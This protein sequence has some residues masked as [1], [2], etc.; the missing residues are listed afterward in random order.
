MKP[1][2]QMSPQCVY[3]P[4]LAG[5]LLLWASL[6]LCQMV[7]SRV[8]Y[9]KW[10]PGYSKCSIN[11]TSRTFVIKCPPPQKGLAAHLYS[12]EKLL[13]QDATSCPDRYVLVSRWA[14]IGRGRAIVRRG[15]TA[16]FWKPMESHCKTN[17][18]RWT[19]EDII[20][21]L[22]EDEDKDWQSVCCLVWLW[23]RDIPW[24]A[25]VH[26]WWSIDHFFFISVNFAIMEQQF[27]NQKQ[28][29]KCHQ[30]EQV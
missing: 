15:R 30:I 17:K 14:S 28:S 26:T 16:M 21:L 23:R 1:S 18:N 9:P 5:P 25:F 29:A 8:G 6:S 7:Q 4:A 10:V 13:V 24:L 3:H 12:Y 11:M 2:C 22:E 19:V 20:W 27:Q